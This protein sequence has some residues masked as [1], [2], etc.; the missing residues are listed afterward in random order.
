MWGFAL[1]CSRLSSSGALSI[2]KPRSSA[3]A[4]S[5]SQPAPSRANAHTWTHNSQDVSNCNA[6][7][8]MSARLD[9][10]N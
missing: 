3:S 5:G 2:W 7:C 8:S 6:E 1:T 10:S 4:A 9:V